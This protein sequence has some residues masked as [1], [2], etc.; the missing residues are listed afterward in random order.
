MQAFSL[1][2]LI[3]GIYVS[4]TAALH[5]V[6]INISNHSL[7]GKGFNIEL[8]TASQYSILLVENEQKQAARNF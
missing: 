5:K 1:P 2:A 7:V 4:V 6:K 3:S 8:Q